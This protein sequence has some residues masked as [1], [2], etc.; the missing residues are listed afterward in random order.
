MP[1]FS[2]PEAFNVMIKELQG[3]CIDVELDLLLRGNRLDLHTNK[4]FRYFRSI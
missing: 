1:V 4:Y 3:L 2:A